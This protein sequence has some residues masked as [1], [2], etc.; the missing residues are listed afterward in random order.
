VKIGI[1]ADTHDNIDNVRKAIRRFKE[2]V[3]LIIHAGDFIFPGIID[4][5]GIS[6]NQYW[7]PNLM[8]V[9]G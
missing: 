5:F 1:L 7:H 2:N 9:L 6:Q 8:G 4:E 3:E